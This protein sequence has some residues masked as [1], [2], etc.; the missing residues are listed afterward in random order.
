MKPL[1]AEEIAELRKLYAGGIETA[2]E[3]RAAVLAA[4]PFLLDEVERSRALRA[5]LASLVAQWREEW[6]R[7]DKP[8]YYASQYSRADQHAEELAALMAEGL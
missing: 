8:D 1:T 3:W 2:L 6:L 4:H 7:D 5:A